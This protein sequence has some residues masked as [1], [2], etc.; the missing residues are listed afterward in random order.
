M[1]R[2]RARPEV[3]GRQ[4][5][6]TSLAA[7]GCESLRLQLAC[8]PGI[9]RTFPTRRVRLGALRG[10]G[11]KTPSVWPTLM[12]WSRWLMRG[13]HG[14]QT[15]LRR[16]FVERSASDACSGAEMC[17]KFVCHAGL[18]AVRCMQGLN[19]R[20]A[21]YHVREERG[22]MQSMLSPGRIRAFTSLCT[23]QPLISFVTAT[24]WNLSDNTAASA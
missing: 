19:M 24:T 10:G 16:L 7:A 22:L 4:G 23:R 1:S 6:L 11:Q 14:C 18:L 17:F 20:G 8:S 5:R 21:V 12:Q 13:G 9:R 2:G 15:G 3:A